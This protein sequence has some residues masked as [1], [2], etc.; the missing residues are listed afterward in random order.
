M[1]LTL[2][3]LAA[4]CRKAL[5]ADSGIAGRR[6]VCALV[7]DACKDR[8]FVAAHFTDKTGP[9]DII[10][11]DPELGFCICAHSYDDARVSRTIMAPPG[12]SMAKSRA[13]R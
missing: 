9:K 11:E 7:E 5:K 6:Q 8:D 2:D 3:Q 13:R 12:Q 1:S 10:Y 4:E